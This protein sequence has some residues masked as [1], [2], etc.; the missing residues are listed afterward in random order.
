MGPLARQIK[1]TQVP[2]GRVALFSLAQAGFCVKAGGAT[3]FLDAYLSDACERLFGFRRL[4]PAP[5]AVEE[6]EA[7]LWASTHAHADHL[8]P[9]ALPILAWRRG[10]HFLGA[11]DCAPAY[12]ELGLPA[13]R[14]TVL[15][16]GESASLQ[17]IKVVATYADHGDLAPEAIGL[18]LECGGVSIYHVGDSAYAPERI[19]ASLPGPVDIMISPIN[20][21]FGNMDAEETCRLGALVRPRLLVAC[22]FG[23]FAE[24]GGDPGAF[25]AAGRELPEG[26]RPV[27]MAPGEKLLWPPA[28]QE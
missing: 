17:G 18:H 3:V 8:D 1:A 2:A 11:A 28:E 12:R 10:T 22:H 9:D 14:C 20:G 19:L 27:V 6:V 16:V 25:L 24:H 5:L 21:Q 13:E 4:I 7:A 23:M 26:V 15:K